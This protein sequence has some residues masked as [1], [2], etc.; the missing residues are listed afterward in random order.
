[1]ER[2]FRLCDVSPQAPTSIGDVDQSSAPH[3]TEELE[4]Q[5][6]RVRPGQE[7]HA[8]VFLLQRHDQL[9]REDI[10]HH[11]P[12]RELHRTRRSRASSRGVE[13]HC[14]ILEPRRCDSNRS[15][16]SRLAHDVPAN[17]LELIRK[18]EVIPAQIAVNAVDADH[19]CLFQRCEPL[20]VGLDLVPKLLGASEED[21]GL[22][23]VDDMHPLG[24]RLLL[25]QRNKDRL[26]TPRRKGCGCPLDRVPPQI[27]HVVPGLH[28]ESI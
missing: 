23:V 22:G 1:M 12:V 28:A 9:P 24:R 3:G 17:L 16:L 8:D 18:P 25:V 19:L 13:P 4:R 2:G 6:A 10:G 11:V 7:A 20:L 14:W 15:S 27:R 26:E 5:A 21:F